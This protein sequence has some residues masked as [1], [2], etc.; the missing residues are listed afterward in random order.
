MLPSYHP[1]QALLHDEG[2]TEFCIVT[3]PTG[4]AIAESERLLIALEVSSG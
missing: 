4:L 2:M 3:I 1:S